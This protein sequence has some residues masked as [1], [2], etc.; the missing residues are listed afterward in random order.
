[1]LVHRCLISRIYFVAIMLV[2]LGNLINFYLVRV[3]R[4]QD[5]VAWSYKYHCIFIFL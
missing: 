4:L 5:Y 3:H 1:M 2:V